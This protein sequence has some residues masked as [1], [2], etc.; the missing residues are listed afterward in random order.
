MCSFDIFKLRKEFSSEVESAIAAFRGLS[1]TSSGGHADLTA[2]FR[3]AAHEA[4][5][6]R[7][8]NRIFRVVSSGGCFSFYVCLLTFDYQTTDLNKFTAYTK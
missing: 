7:A 1:T 2:L 4:K 5:K 3:V 6:S 8:Q